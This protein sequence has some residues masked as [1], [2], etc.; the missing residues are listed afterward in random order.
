MRKR[1][2]MPTNEPT[3]QGGVLG[4]VLGA[5]NAVSQDTR[6]TEKSVE[7]AAT[8]APIEPIE[9]N[10]LNS[11]TEA[12]AKAEKADLQAVDGG[13]AEEGRASKPKSTP[14]KP[15]TPAKERRA[16]YLTSEVVAE[17]RGCVETLMATPEHRMSLNE[18]V[19]KALRRE[20]KRLAK[21][22]NEG[23]SFNAPGQHLP[24][25]RTVGR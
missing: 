3:A 6:P 13:R 1:S 9:R 21:A 18:L 25:G 23:E 7:P 14:A 15:A 22:H 10:E 5:A 19:E 16:F 8:K 12:A 24:V 2:T 11:E 20:L 17:A 4:P